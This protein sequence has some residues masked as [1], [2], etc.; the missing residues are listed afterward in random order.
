[1][2]NRQRQHGLF[3]SADFVKNEWIIN[4]MEEQYLIQWNHLLEFNAAFKII[5]FF[6][7]IYK[8]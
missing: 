6:K 5:Q 4:K 3:M 7:N 2:E 1:M 8:I